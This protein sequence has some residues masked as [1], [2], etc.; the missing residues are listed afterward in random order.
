MSDAEWESKEE[1]E[2]AIIDQ[3]VS[4][5][6]R[7]TTPPKKSQVLT[8]CLPNAN[9]FDTCHL[10]ANSIDGTRNLRTV[11]VNRIMKALRITGILG[12]ICGVIG[13]IG[14]FVGG[15]FGAFVAGA[16]P[17]IMLGI[18]LLVLL[19]IPQGYK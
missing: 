5:H 16:L 8:H 1:L 7:S 2:T 19:V 17:G 9:D 14:F 4:L 15:E 12:I 11:V 13:Y 6:C 18:S 10:Y 3:L